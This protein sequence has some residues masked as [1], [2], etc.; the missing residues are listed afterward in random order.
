MT[1]ALG[2][3]R[4][5]WWATARR[6]CAFGLSGPRV[7]ALQASA[8]AFVVQNGQTVESA[9]WDSMGA[10]FVGGSP[11]CHPCWYVRPGKDQRK[12]CPQCGRPLTEWKCGPEAAALVSHANGLGLWTH[13]GRVNTASRI[14]IR[15]GH[16]MPV[17]GWLLVLHALQHPPSM[18]PARSSADP[19]FRRQRV[20]VYL[21]GAINGCSDVEAT[22]WRE[23]VK[24]Q[25]PGI[26][27]ID[28]MRRDYRGKEDE[29][30]N[31]IVAG[32]L[33]DIYA[34]DV[35]LVAADRP[36]WGTAMECFY[37]FNVGKRVI[38]VC[39]QDRVSPW[40]RYHS[41]LL[42]PTMAA[43]VAAILTSSEPSA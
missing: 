31:E 42:V 14:F 34:S 41:S 7:S 18:G 36:S 30:V 27:C 4:P 1:I 32:D 20:K 16:R 17:R 10:L 2:S 40:L 21:C 37:A 24:A 26:E 22:G 25:L 3:A 38:V 28:P 13:M 15:E 29:S 6:P 33:E 23:W 9:P 12:I 19:A 43:A 11:E 35:I 8:P 39:G 5:T